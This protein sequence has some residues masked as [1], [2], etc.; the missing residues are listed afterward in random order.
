[1]SHN[2]WLHKL[3]RAAIVRPL[4]GTTITPNQLTTLRLGTGIAASAL[5]ASGSSIA[6]NAGA[7]M[8]VISVILDRAD[9][10]FA[11]QTDQQM[12]RPSFE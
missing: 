11:R 12:A 8:F 7:G 2:T 9:G 10:D 5:I 3:S 1:M 4:L 6:M